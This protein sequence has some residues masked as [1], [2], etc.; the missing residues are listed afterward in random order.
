MNISIP[1]ETLDQFLT[2]L[3]KIEQQ[4]AAV[5]YYVVHDENN[6]IKMITAQKEL[7][8]KPCMYVTVGEN[9]VAPYISGE[10]SLFNA[11]I[12]P[13]PGTTDYRIG[14]KAVDSRHLR[15]I[16]LVATEIPY[17]KDAMIS[18]AVD[19]DRIICRI[20][21]QAHQAMDDDLTEDVHVHIVPVDNPNYVLETHLINIKEVSER[22]EI[23][24]KSAYDL[25]N[26]T[27]YA[28]NPG[29]VGMV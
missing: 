3:K 4:Q 12:E 13:I 18:F 29:Y 16:K 9:L 7:L 10:K 24:I 21:K 28:K 26:C 14:Y 23:I 25:S 22:G 19:K 17:N 27:L 1:K 20:T 11:I 8:K 6:F 15:S 2:E 5:E